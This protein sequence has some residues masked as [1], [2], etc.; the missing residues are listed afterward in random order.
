M[1][2]Y[3]VQPYTSYYTGELSGHMIELN[4][5]VR[6]GI[7]SIVSAAHRM[8]IAQTR[9]ANGYEV[10]RAFIVDV[11]SGQALLAREAID[12]REYHS[13]DVWYDEASSA[14]DISDFIIEVVEYDLNNDDKSA[15]RIYESLST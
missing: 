7:R 15:Q 10:K 8:L 4:A 2:I 1:N 11:E 14:D 5:D 12:G 13:V 9:E 6:A 3:T